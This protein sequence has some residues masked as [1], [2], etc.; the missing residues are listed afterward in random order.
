MRFCYANRRHT[1]FPISYEYT[2][3]KP[4]NYT[5][6]FL[7]KTKEIGFDA[8]EIGLETFEYIGQRN[9]LLDFSSKRLWALVFSMLPA[10]LS[11]TLFLP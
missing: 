2:D 9:E 3:L 4:D 10:M 6:A 7:S 5:D 1:I 11:K 8:L